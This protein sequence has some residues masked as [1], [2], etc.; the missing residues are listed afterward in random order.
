MTTRPSSESARELRF[1]LLATFLWTW[2]F[3]LGLYA[4]TSLGVTSAGR[5]LFIALHM[6][7]GLGPTVLAIVCAARRPGKRTVHAFLRTW[8]PGRLTPAGALVLAAGLSLIVAKPA[9]LRILGH[10]DRLLVDGWPLMLA[11]FPVM[12]VGGGLEEPGW[13]GIIYDDSE[14]LRNGSPGALLAMAIV[15]ILWHLPLWLIPGTYQNT[16]MDLGVF[17]LGVGWSTLLYYAIR[18]SGASVGWCILAHAFY[19]T[20][21]P[22]FTPA[23]SLSAER[24]VSLVLLAAA[25]ALFLVFR[26]VVGKVPD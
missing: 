2:S 25:C 23:A 19:N 17:A 8:L 24:L 13:R 5:P 15:W 7:G 12:I 16:S 22:A 26:K 21:M 10:S 3:W 9:A 1:F 4:L 18:L 6:A 14:T 20:T 11:L